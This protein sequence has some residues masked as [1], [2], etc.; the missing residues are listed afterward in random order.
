MKS[1]EVRAEQQAVQLKPN[2]PV[3]ETLTMSW[4]ELK[5]SSADIDVAVICDFDWGTVIVIEELGANNCC[6]QKSQSTQSIR[7]CVKAFWKVTE[8]RRSLLTSFFSSHN[9][10]NDNGLFIAKERNSIFTQKQF[11]CHHHLSK[12]EFQIV[13][14]NSSYSNER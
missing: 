3:L 7:H 9:P 8:F 13:M 12:I 5:K 1:Q 6:H 2:F 4:V 10:I 14:Q 11:L